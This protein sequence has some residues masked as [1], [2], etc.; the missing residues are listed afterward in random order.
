MICI[1]NCKNCKNWV[2]EEED[3]GFCEST[4]FN[5]AMTVIFDNDESEI[6]SIY[7]DGYQT[8]ACFGCIYFE[9]K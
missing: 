5:C 2:E 7:I 3:K 4:E 9:E 8:T 1:K 6:E